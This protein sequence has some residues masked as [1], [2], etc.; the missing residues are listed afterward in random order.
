[1][2]VLITGGAG[3]IGSHTTDLL[4][5]R[6]HDVVILDKLEQQVHGDR[7]PDYLNQKAEFVQGEITKPETWKKVLCDVNAVIHLAAMV[8]VGQSMYQPLRYLETNTLGTANL[9]KVLLEN[10]EL[11]KN[12]RKIIVASSKSIYGEGAYECRTHGV[13]YPDLRPV[14]QL[15]KKDWEVHCPI[16]GEYVKPV[17]ITEA[18]P[19]QNLSVYALSKFDAERLALMY[20]NALQIT[21]IAFRYFN[22]YGPRQSLN[23]PYTGVCAIFMSRIKNNNSPF[24]YE[25]GNQMRD[26]VY[27][28]DIAKVNVLAL[29][30]SKDMV[31]VFNVGTGK[32]IS[33]LN[34]AKTLAEIYGS[35]VEPKITEE[36][37]FGDNRHDFA[38]I[39]KI[40]KSLGWEPSIELKTGL[41][42]L[43]K[44]SEEQKAVDRFVEAEAE[45][46]KYFA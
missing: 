34:M 19:A 37:R 4:I 35:S 42:K 26:F 38:D 20:G 36:F 6:G 29:E 7:K 39:T 41:E 3:F 9:F 33:I 43:V 30:S 11:R 23:N 15:E 27:V 40:K 28:E 17:G 18:K 44:W 2:K 32:P 24:I 5:E 16:C 45:R 14:E 46:K 25:D 12:V 13:V 1:M 8:G 22:V 10:K 31:D 21:T